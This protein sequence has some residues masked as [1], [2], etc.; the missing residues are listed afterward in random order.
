VQKA[1]QSKEEA[2]QKA[3]AK[4][5]KEWERNYDR[6]ICMKE[7]YIRQRKRLTKPDI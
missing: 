7:K 5:L 2:K 6:E 3:V 4:F 1:G